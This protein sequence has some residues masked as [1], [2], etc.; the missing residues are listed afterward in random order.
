MDTTK[1]LEAKIEELEKENCELKNNI[2]TM[3]NEQIEELEKERRQLS[4]ELAIMEM[5]RSF[6]ELWHRAMA[7]R[8][9]YEETDTA[10]ML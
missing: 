6:Y 4:I 5:E 2:N 9:I 1:K 3:I 8:G 10:R 7:E